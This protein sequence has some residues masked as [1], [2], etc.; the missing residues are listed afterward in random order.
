MKHFLINNISFNDAY[1]I[2][3]NDNWF[4]TGNRLNKERFIIVN[5]V[6]GN[7]IERINGI[8]SLVPS[9]LKK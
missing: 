5:I 2:F 9:I 8:F 1:H 6:K 7:E 4:N 3:V